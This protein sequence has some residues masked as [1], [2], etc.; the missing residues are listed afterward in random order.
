MPLVVLLPLSGWLVLLGA[1]VQHSCH[2]LG[3]QPRQEEQGE[4]GRA[5]G[6]ASWDQIF[7]LWAASTPP[8]SCPAGCPASSLVG[9][10]VGQPLLVPSTTVPS[11]PRPAQRFVGSW[12]APS[13]IPVGDE[14]T[15]NE[16]PVNQ[17]QPTGLAVLCLRSRKR[18]PG[19][20]GGWV[21]L[22]CRISPQLAIEA[23]AGR[24]TCE[25]RTQELSSGRGCVFVT[26]PSRLLYFE[27]EM[28]FS[29][30]LWASTQQVPVDTHLL[31]TMQL[32]NLQADQCDYSPV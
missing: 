20:P 16:S 12:N 28:E 13:L 26:V 2:R 4:D 27:S 25:H 23:L 21:R 11:V 10:V 9:S 22:A 18:I 1:W 17:M 14:P 3:H 15:S 29:T 8:G 19:Q 6:R 31:P 30:P 24:H 5:P 7:S 32:A